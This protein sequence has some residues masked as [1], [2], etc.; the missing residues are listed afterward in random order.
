MSDGRDW[1]FVIDGLC[2]ECG[3]DGSKVAAPDV[4]ARLR[5][6]AATYRSLLQ[7][8]DAV[9]RR[10]SPEAWSALEYGCHVRDVCSKGIERV[11]RM[12]RESDPE[13][14]DWDEGETALTERY[15]EQDPATVAYRL[16]V[17]AG[18]L[19]DL[20]DK[21]SGPAWHRPGRRSDGAVFTIDT[22]ARYLLHDVVHHIHDIEIGYEKLTDRPT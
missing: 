19:A 16:A 17:E 6:A 8:G 10:P 12:I 18:K 11:T 7:R 14:L 4:A 21:V 13:F 22:L 20:F 15:A 2:P 9:T 1:T 5:A 3:Y